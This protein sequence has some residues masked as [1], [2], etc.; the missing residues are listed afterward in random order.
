MLSSDPRAPWLRLILTPGVGPGQQRQL[1][2]AFGPPERIYAA[3]HSAIAA[4]VGGPAARTLLDHDATPAVE[5]ALEWLSRP[6]NSLLTLGDEA[7]PPALLEIPDPP[8]ALYVKG[9]AALLSRP[10]LAVVGARN[11]TPQGEAN[12]ES[13][14]RALSEAGLGI[15]S[16]LAL[17]IDAAAHR[18]GLAGPGSTVAV[19]GTG[20]DRIYPARNA[21]LAR[22]IAEAGAI[23]SEFPL[24]IGP[25]AHN[26]PR[27]NRLIAGLAQGVLV[28]EAALKSGSLITARLATDCGR[29]VFAIP[30]S[31]HSPVARGCHQLIRDG[32]KLV[33]T[34]VD[35]L[36]ELRLAPREAAPQ[37]ASA[38]DDAEGD[39]ALV[40]CAMGHDPVDMDAL[41]QRTNLTAEALYAILL[42]LELDGRVSR[43][44]GGRLQR[45]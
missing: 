10:S 23:I 29:E 4:V 17:G 39:E 45:L 40:I 25:L 24:G 6:G 37:L 27:R 43:L 8:V 14:S 13:F 34:A 2:A 3:G 5:T 38:P 31:I 1:L 32:A 26:F 11:A 35:I 19:I 15:V 44:P 7:Y 33:E 28:V 36:D 20:A 41:V 22:Q 30:G 9:D 21:A 16:G 12:A 42:A 18:G